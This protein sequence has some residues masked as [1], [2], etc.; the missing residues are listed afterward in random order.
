M[1]TA[2]A[3]CATWSA[4]RTGVCSCSVGLPDACWATV[5]AVGPARGCKSRPRAG[6]AVR[7]AT[8]EEPAPMPKLP[9][10][11]DDA[12]L[13]HVFQRYPATS[14]PLLEYHQILLRGPSPLSV[15]ERELIAAYVSG[16]N[17]CHYCHG[18]HSATAQAFGVPEGTLADLLERVE[19]ARVDARLTPILH[20]V[21]KLTLNAHAPDR[22][23]RP[24][25]LR[26]GLGR[27]GAARCGQRCRSVQPDEPSGR[28][29]RDRC[30]AGV[31]RR[32][33]PAPVARRL[34]GAAAD[35]WPGRL[36]HARRPAPAPTGLR[37]HPR[38]ARST[39]R[40]A[41]DAAIVSLARRAEEEATR[42]P[43]A[44]AQSAAKQ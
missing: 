30:R 2:N 37:P 24:G 10:L 15:A 26:R 6:R 8:V 17:Q 43:A 9:S 4:P 36:S 32:G 38:F 29:P 11:P 25:G 19:G 39:T 14:R 1:T 33:W 35:P 20:Y 5:L 41:P 44:R 13:L 22:S 12:R 40:C 34:P 31:L 18:V 7:S 42:R 3:R 16:L 23:R 28:G 27:A 21:H